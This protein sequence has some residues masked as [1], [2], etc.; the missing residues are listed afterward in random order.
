[1]SAPVQVGPSPQGDGPT[2]SPDWGELLADIG[3][4]VRAERLARQ[5]TQ[6]ELGRRTGIGLNTVKRLEEGGASSL[7]VF[8]RVCTVLDVLED[9][10][11]AQWELPPVRPYLSPQQVRVLGAVADGR[12][13]QDAARGLCMTSGGVAS[14]LTSVYRRLGVAGVPRGKRRAAAVRVAREH[15]L[16]DIP[17]RTS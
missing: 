2:P 3:D 15:H 13:L 5:W 4:R 8:V 16:I 14:V 12:P 10:L 1:M 11:S 6:T 7:A 17:N 9:V